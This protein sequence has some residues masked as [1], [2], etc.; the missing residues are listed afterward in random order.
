MERVEVPPRVDLDRVRE[1]CRQRR[2]QEMLG[3]WLPLDEV[4]SLL[5]EAHLY[6]T[7]YDSSARRQRDGARARKPSPPRITLENVDRYDAE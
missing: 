1:M 3:V 4:E 7:K 2:E 6:R 5:I